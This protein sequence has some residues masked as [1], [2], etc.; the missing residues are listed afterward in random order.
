[1]VRLRLA[2]VLVM[3]AGP[4]IAEA[5]LQQTYLSVYLEINDAER[6]ELGKDYIGALVRFQ[7]AEA[8]LVKM[9]TCDANWEIDLL[10]HRIK[11]C[12]EEI[13]KLTPLAAKE[14]SQS[15]DAW[16]LDGEKLG[17]NG[18]SEV[19]QSQTKLTFWQLMK[20]NHPGSDQGVFDQKIREGSK[21]VDEL[22]TAAVE[23]VSAST[24]GGVRQ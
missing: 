18:W 1:M 4:S 15:N 3:L 12:Q 20:L 17:Q 13:T 16:P 22:V 7:V 10:Q 24:P 19:D 9:H 5:T 8:F 11:D 21:T 2:V 14:L 23:K 6:S